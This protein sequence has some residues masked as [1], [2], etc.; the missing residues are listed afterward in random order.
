MATYTIFN[1]FGMEMCTYWAIAYEG[2]YSVGICSQSDATFSAIVYG[3]KHA[4]AFLYSAA[5]DPSQ[6]KYTDAVKYSCSGEY[7][8]MLS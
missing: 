1:S 6:N 3:A 8:F 4:E 5:F 2:T 7:E